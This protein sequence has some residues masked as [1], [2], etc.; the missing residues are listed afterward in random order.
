M[1]PMSEPVL[2]EPAAAGDA[3]AAASRS[4]RRRPMS[5][6]DD[7]FGERRYRVRGLP[8][9]LTEALKVNVLVTRVAPMVRAPTR[10][11]HVDTLDLYQAKAARG[12]RQAGRPSSCASRNT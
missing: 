1:Q 4:R 2:P 5:S 6:S 12:V 3:R 9:Q 8:K 10:R 11:L 7:H